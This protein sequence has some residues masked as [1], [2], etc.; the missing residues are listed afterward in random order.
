MNC[1]TVKLDYV[2]P[3]LTGC[4]SS[5]FFFCVKKKTKHNRSTISMPKSTIFVANCKWLKK[6]IK[7]SFTEL[8]SN[9]NRLCSVKPALKK[10]SKY[11]NKF[12]KL[13]KKAAEFNFR[14]QLKVVK[15]KEFTLE[16]EEKEVSCRWIRYQKWSM[17][18]T[19]YDYKYKWR[20]RLCIRH[21]L[22]EI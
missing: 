17:I 21:Y 10:V 1:K 9:L 15:K 19:I 7:M 13:Q 18:I 14:N 6:N 20:I 8:K 12:A 16:E 4:L 5:S 2:K 3:K 11:E 22:I